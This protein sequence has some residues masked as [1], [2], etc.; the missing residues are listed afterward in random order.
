MN[1]KRIFQNDDSVQQAITQGLGSIQGGGEQYINLDT[2]V[3]GS[4]LDIMNNKNTRNKGMIKYGGT[5]ELS[6]AKY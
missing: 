1:Q 4:D 6:G 3:G 2:E 5:I